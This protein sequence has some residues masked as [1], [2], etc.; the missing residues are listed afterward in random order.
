MF[1]FVLFCVLFVFLCVF[2]QPC[3]AAAPTVEEFDDEQ[4][5][6]CAAEIEHGESLSVPVEE[7]DDEQTRC[8]AAETERGESLSVPV[9]EF[10]VIAKSEFTAAVEQAKRRDLRCMSAAEIRA[11]CREHG[12]ECSSRGRISARVYE[13]LAAVI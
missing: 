8:C 11:L 6:C 5:R 4:T 12:I 2:I 7:F 13:R 3:E 9:E 10:D 1:G